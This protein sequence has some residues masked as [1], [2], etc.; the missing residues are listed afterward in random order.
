MTFKIPSGADDVAILH[1]EDYT[2]EVEKYQR[3]FRQQLHQHPG[4]ETI[5]SKLSAL[6]AFERA[7]PQLTSLSTV[8]LNALITKMREAGSSADEQQIRAMVGY[9]LSY[10]L[11]YD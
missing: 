11:V 9:V 2:A 3:V 5:S 1:A 7:L 10:E 4:D 6:S 8:P